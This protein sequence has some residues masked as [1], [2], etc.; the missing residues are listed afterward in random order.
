MSFARRRTCLRKLLTWSRPCRLSRRHGKMAGLR[1][2]V[3]KR[4]A[5]KYSL[6]LLE[7]LRSDRLQWCCPLLG[8]YRNLI[9][10]TASAILDLVR[11]F[12]TIRRIFPL[13]IARHPMIITIMVVFTTTM[14]ILEIRGSFYTLFALII[15]T[16]VHIRWENQI[17]QSIVP[18]RQRPLGRRFA[19]RL[20]IQSSPLVV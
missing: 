13:G 5:S 16:P 10:I 8:L 3:L 7:I 6:R 12:L 19:M 15:H 1:R 11:C 4:F 9:T 20:G 17:R 2:V 14:E 18:V